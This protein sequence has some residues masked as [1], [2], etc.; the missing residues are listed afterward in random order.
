MLA[1][2]QTALGTKIMTKSIHSKTKIKS[3]KQLTPIKRLF[4]NNPPSAQQVMD[5]LAKQPDRSRG[6]LQMSWGPMMG[7]HSVAYEVV[8]KKPVIFDTQS[9]KTYSTPS[10]LNALTQRAQGLSFNRLDN[11][12][13]NEI[14][15][16]A[17]M[18]DA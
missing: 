2:G 14:G 12:N 4:V 8:N 5:T 10:E 1:S 3:T 6:D 7:G 17:W 13:L 9:G 16:T 11:K 15:L 18:K